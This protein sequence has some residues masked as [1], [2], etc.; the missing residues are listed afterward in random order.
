[1]ESI[2]FGTSGGWFIKADTE[3]PYSYYRDHL[4]HGDKFHKDIHTLNY[5]KDIT[6][7]MEKWFIVHIYVL[8]LGPC[9]HHIYT[10][11]DNKFVNRKDVFIE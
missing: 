11:K 8:M 4:G 2:E 1:M 6:S 10:I 5:S 9:G 3:K 7:F